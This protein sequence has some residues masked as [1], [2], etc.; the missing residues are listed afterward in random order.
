MVH[1]L[2][3][4]RHYIIGKRTEIYKDHKSVKY[5]YTQPDLNLRHRR[6]LEFIKDYDVGINYHPGKVNIVA[7]ALSRRSNC[8]MLKI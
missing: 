8:D 3:I 1:A 2:K 5:I 6:W 4:W 7:D